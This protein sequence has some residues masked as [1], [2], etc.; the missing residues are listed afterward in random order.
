MNRPPS[1]EFEK[2]INEKEQ[3]QQQ[4]L[5]ILRLEVARGFEQL[6]AGEKPSKNAL[7]IFDEVNWGIHG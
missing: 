1:S 2:R 4:Q 7:D 5:K 3:L 6:T